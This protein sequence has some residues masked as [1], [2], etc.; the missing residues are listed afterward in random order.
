MTDSFNDYP[1]ISPV[2]PQSQELARL[3]HQVAQYQRICEGSG[4]GFW[5]WNLTNQS[6]EMKGSFWQQLGYSD[7]DL[8]VITSSFQV[9]P[10][11][12]PKD[13][14]GLLLNIRSQ[15]KYSV[16]L[17]VELRI[18]A[19]DGSYVWSQLRGESKR[20]AAGRVLYVTGVIFD[21]TPLKRAEAA[22]Q[23]SQARQERII[24]SSNDGLWEWQAGGQG[25]HFSSRCWD[26]I[27]YSAEDDEIVQNTDRWHI[28]RSRMHPDDVPK[29]DQMLDRHYRFQEPFD[30]E[31][32][33]FGKD[34]HTHWIR[35]RGKASF[36]NNG[37][38]LRM[39]GT[40][41]DI[42]K[43]KEAEE[44][45]IKAKEVAEQANQAKSEFLSSMSHE[46]RTPLNAI[47]GYTQLFDYDKNLSD[48]QLN[49]IREIRRAGGL[50]LQLIGDVL[51]LSKID[52]GNLTLSL[53]PV[54]P[55]RLLDECLS[56]TATQAE[57]KSVELVKL[58]DDSEELWVTADAVRLKQTLLNLITNAIKYNRAGG[59]VEICFAPVPETNRLR[60][61]IRDTGLGISDD[62]KDQ[63][64]EPFNRLGAEMGKEEGTGVGLVITKRLVEMMGGVIDFDS[65]EGE[66]SCFW[67]DLPIATDWSCAW[68]SDDTHPEP[69][70]EVMRDDV[71]ARVLYIEDNPSNIRLMEQF[72]SHFDNLQLV[73]CDESFSG[74]Y[75]A[76][77]GN[78]DAIILDINLPGMDGFEILEILN[79]DPATQS[80]PKIGLSANAMAYDIERALQAGFSDYLTKPLDIA[81]LS[82]VLN[83]LLD[84]SAA[85]S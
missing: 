72:F 32:R 1:D 62:R 41:I 61:A 3:E 55:L 84:S 36:D 66:G 76:R 6:F 52:S 26:M 78:F 47:L 17:I 13:R 18:A 48:D 63:V 38:P 45:V 75:E 9:P 35:G 37:N 65:T 40:N 15:F 74:L 29:F 57:K 14:S 11:V 4:Y 42:T 50:L 2:D 27:G 67:V 10:L 58:V 16:P 28:W 85:E 77:T 53:E 81:R 22:L 25:I 20:N 19:K 31:Y 49:N 7:E 71:S 64:F 51:D 54:M 60:M 83:R 12:H 43:L 23:D 33:I 80:T 73:C 68:N 30:I 5:E 82:G 46:L 44:R 79:Q 21:I 34:G 8:A 69:S 59:K 24:Q 70:L 39:S 56:M